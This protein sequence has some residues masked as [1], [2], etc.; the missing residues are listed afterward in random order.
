MSAWT[1]WKAASRFLFWATVETL[2][3]AITLRKKAAIQATAFNP[4]RPDD[5]WRAGYVIFYCDL[6]RDVWVGT[7]RKPGEKEG[8]LLSPQFEVTMQRGWDELPWHHVS[9]GVMPH[10]GREFRAVPLD[11]ANKKLLMFNVEAV[12]R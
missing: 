10:D 3:R 12:E 8:E 1:A 11:Y 5:M 2:T 9:F 6:N 4:Q 7:Y